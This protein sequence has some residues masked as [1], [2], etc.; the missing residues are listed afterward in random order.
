MKQ[1]LLE[2]RYPLFIMEL[3]RD[4]TELADIDAICNYFR[5]CIEAHRCARFIAEFDHYA[6]TRGLPEGDV[7][8]DIRAARNIIFCF[9]ISLPSAQMLA[10]RPRSIGVAETDQG[11]VISF[12]ETPMP[13]ANAA[14]EDWAEGLRRESQASPSI[15]AAEP[16]RGPGRAP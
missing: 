15:T 14:M 3:G 9:G 10:V 12:M 4:E 13:I 5:R 7:A 11:F 6:H 2:E 8:A 1:T 16:A